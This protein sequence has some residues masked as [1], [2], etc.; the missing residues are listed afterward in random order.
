MF[1]PCKTLFLLAL[2]AATSPQEGFGAPAAP[3]KPSGVLLSQ[4]VGMVAGD[5]FTSRE[6]ALSGLL[7]RLWVAPAKDPGA[8]TPADSE[9]G[10]REQSAMLLEEAVSR[11]SAAFSVGTASSGEIE[12]L[13]E[14]AQKT[15]SADGNWKRLDFTPEELKRAVTRKLNAKSMIRIKSESMRGPIPDSDAAAYFEKN[16]IKFGNLPFSAFKENI[17]TLLQEQQLEERLR[18]WFEILRRKYKVRDLASE[19]H[20]G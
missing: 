1:R 6:A 4:T 9:A 10:R 7:E 19:G 15:L 2:L 11:E 8:P 3:A 18:S 14:K 12:K 20:R 17:K 13:S 16:R 5:V